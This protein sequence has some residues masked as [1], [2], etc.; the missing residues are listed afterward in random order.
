MVGCLVLK[1]ASYVQV[2]GW[3]LGAVGFVW[4]GSEFGD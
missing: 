4:A 2:W 3:I 1:L